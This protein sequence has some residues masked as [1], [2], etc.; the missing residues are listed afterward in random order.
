MK[1]L[2]IGFI[3]ITIITIILWL[4]FIF[5]NHVSIITALVGNFLQVI[6]FLKIRKEYKLKIKQDD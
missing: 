2:R 1:E 6:L 4:G 3:I 5:T